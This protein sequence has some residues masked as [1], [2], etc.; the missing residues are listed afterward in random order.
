[1]LV[2]ELDETK[3]NEAIPIS[4]SNHAQFLACAA[5]VNAIVA[6]VVISNVFIF[7]FGLARCQMCFCQRGW[8]T[9]EIFRHGHV[10]PNATPAPILIARQS[11]N[12]SN[13]ES[14]VSKV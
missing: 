10:E 1:L 6:I 2:G 8:F 5:W 9:D 4:P 12:Q 3:G 13:S 11:D 7:Y 14:S